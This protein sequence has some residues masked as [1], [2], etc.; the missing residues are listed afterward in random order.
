MKIIPKIAIELDRQIAG[1]IKLKNYIW[2]FAHFEEYI[3]GNLSLILSKLRVFEKSYWKLL[4][5]DSKKFLANFFDLMVLWNV[6]TCTGKIHKY[7]GVLLF[8]F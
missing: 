7:N 4:S 3:R 8:E 1:Q 5:Q 6:Q 2:K